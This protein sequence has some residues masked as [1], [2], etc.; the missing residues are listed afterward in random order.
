MSVSIP[1]RLV[2]QQRGVVRCGVMSDVVDQKSAATFEHGEHDL[3]HLPLRANVGEYLDQQPPK[4]KPPRVLG[5]LE[6]IAR[7]KSA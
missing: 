7:T 4:A 6:L 2:E 1:Y 5:H 3:G